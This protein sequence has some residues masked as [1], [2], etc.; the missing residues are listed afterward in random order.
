MKVNRAVTEYLVKHGWVATAEKV[1]S[2]LIEG[3]F[4]KEDNLTNPERLAAK[5]KEWLRVKGNSK[6][7]F[8]LA[9]GW[10]TDGWHAVTGQSFENPEQ[11]RDIFAALVILAKEA[12]IKL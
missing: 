1:V 8:K 3:G 6:E 11:V 5:A 12:E 7:A 2:D 10:N 4:I 9:S